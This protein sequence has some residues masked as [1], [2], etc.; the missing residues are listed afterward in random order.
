MVKIAPYSTSTSTTDNNISQMEQSTEQGIQKHWGLGLTEF[1][2]NRFGQDLGALVSDRDFQKLWELSMQKAES[3]PDVEI[4]VTNAPPD[5][6]GD[7]TS[8]DDESITDGDYESTTDDGDE[9]FTA[10]DDES[11][12]GRH[13]EDGIGDVD[14]SATDG[15]DENVYNNRGAADGGIVVETVAGENGFRCSGPCSPGLT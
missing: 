11:A 8:D 7:V 5:D 13:D 3:S 12:T 6:G 2:D 4:K 15:G 9:S 14:E 1:E 10:G